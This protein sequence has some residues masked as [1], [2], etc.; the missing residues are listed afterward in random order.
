M[1]KKTSTSSF[2]RLA[3]GVLGSLSHGLA[4][5]A[6][7]LIWQLASTALSDNTLVPSPMQAWHALVYD[8]P[9]EA[10]LNDIRA[11]LSRVAIGLIGAILVG[12]ALGILLGPMQRIGDFVAA[13]LEYLRPIPPI[14]WIPLAIL[15]F[16]IGELSAWF[17][18]FLAAFFP[19]FTNTFAGARAV[20]PTHRTVA[21][22]LSVNHRM[23]IWHVLIPS[24]LPQIVTGVRV[25]AGFA[26]MA[27]IASEMVAAQSGLGYMIQINRFLLMSD[28][29][30][31]GMVVIGLIG[32]L[33]A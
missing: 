27:V 26:W 19:I 24:A 20:T 9:T 7:L 21:R 1:F 5:L 32:Y 33:S 3:Q 8:I 31:A 10:L 12:V 16:G 6:L 18:I 17:I 14:A 4:F 22:S 23:F 11:S 28:K 30:V 2:S 29:V 13:M 25:A 15:W